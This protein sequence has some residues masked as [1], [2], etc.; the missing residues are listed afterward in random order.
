MRENVG[1]N[2]ARS[3]LRLAE[4]EEENIATVALVQLLRRQHNF[5]CRNERRVEKRE[6][7]EET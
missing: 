6:G 3:R 1:F 2:G 7:V 4:R 5:N